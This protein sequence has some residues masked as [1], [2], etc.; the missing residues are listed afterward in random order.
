MGASFATK[1]KGYGLGALNGELYR[2]SSSANDRISRKI[3]SNDIIKIVVDMNYK[4]MTFIFND[5]E[6]YGIG[7][8]D[9][10][11]LTS[12]FRFAASFNHKTEKIQVLDY[13]INYKS[14]MTTDPNKQELNIKYAL[15]EKK[16][17]LHNGIDTAP[18]D[19]NKS[20]G[21]IILKQWKW[22]S[23]PELYWQDKPKQIKCF[24]NLHRAVE[25]VCRRMR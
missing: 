23:K 2:E 11:T 18:K 25:M 12:S 3:K 17:N 13:V 15:I 8:Q 19:K 24:T 16:K 21:A 1:S 7:H 4:T 22:K 9:I 10:S 5:K 14:P 6:Y 20:I